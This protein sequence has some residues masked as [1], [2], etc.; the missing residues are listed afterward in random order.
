MALIIYN[1]SNTNSLSRSTGRTIHVSK[2][3]ATISFGKELG[4]KE[5]QRVIVA[6]DED[7]PKWYFAIVTENETEA[8]T[9]RRESNGL[10]QFRC[11]F[12]S[13]LI[14]ESLKS[15]VSLKFLVSKEP[16]SIDGTAYYTMIPVLNQETKTKK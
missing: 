4:L 5:G 6:K 12:L 16:V 9:L 14:L 15:N 3:G 13:R 7:Q 8:F 2:S 11:L 1:R 10:I